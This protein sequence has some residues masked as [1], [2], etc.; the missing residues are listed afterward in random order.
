MGKAK[1]TTKVSGKSGSSIEDWEAALIRAMQADPSY[2]QD[3]IISYFTRP[4]RGVNPYRLADLKKGKLHPLV[5]AANAAQLAVYLKTYKNRIEAQQK[6]FEENPLHPVNLNALFRV[7]DG[8]TNILHVDETDRVECKQSF[9]WGNRAEYART[10]AALANARGGYLLFGI[11]DSDKQIVGIAAGK[12][13]KHD[14]SKI[15]QYLLSKFSPVPVWEKSE[16]TIAGMTMGILYV[17]PCATRP[18]ICL[19]DDGSVLREGDVYYRYPG[20]TRRVKSPEITEMIAEHVRRA[21]ALWAQ[22]LARVEKAGVENVA[23]LDTTTGIVA[24]QGGK[25]V[26]DESLI[27]KLKFITEGKLTE[28]DGAPTLRLIGDLQPAAMTSGPVTTVHEPYNLSD[29]DLLR[30]FLAQTNVSNPSLYIERLAL[31]QKSYLPVFY[32]MRLAQ[33]DAAQAIAIVSGVKEITATRL[34]LLSERISKKLS[35]AGAPKPSS[36]EPTRT[37]LLAKAVTPPA[38]DV[39]ALA[40]LKAIRSLKP[41]EIDSNFLLPLLQHCYDNGYGKN[42]GVLRNAIAHVDAA[43]SKQLVSMVD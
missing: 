11:Q 16:M 18:V 32:Y 42:A 6:F 33:M 15:T 31:S 5:P 1:P 24:G 9:N 38:S 8:T 23:I 22:T 17:R 3:K 26:I 7:K 30:A 21:Q 27:P 28:S 41:G 19:S 29:D 39:A 4:D 14:S 35:P 25:F 43:W 10:I 13:S 2:T 37:N 36:V 20:E 12:M 34:K 40:L